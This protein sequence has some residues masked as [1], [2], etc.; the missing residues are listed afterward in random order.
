MGLRSLFSIIGKDFRIFFRSRIASFFVLVFPLII[1]LFA[2]FIFNSFA[3]S[4]VAIGSYSAGYTDLT[5]N[6]LA[7][8][9]ENN[10]EVERFGM[11][12]HCTDAVKSGRVHLCVIFPED[13][14]VA[15]NTE[16][17][18][19]YV[20]HSRINLAY[21]LINDMESQ[22][23]F[24][25]S[26]LGIHL[27]QDL[28]DVLDNVKESIPKRIDSIDSSKS[29]IED[30]SENI[31]SI[32]L[33][34]NLNGIIADL[35][36][37]KSSLNEEQGAIGDSIDDVILSI[38]SLEEINSQISD[39]LSEISEDNLEISD[40]LSRISSDLDKLLDSFDQASVLEAEK[41][42]SPIKTKIERVGED[43]N[44]RDYFFPTLF[45]LIALFGGILLSST[46]I[47]KER[48]TKAYFRNF[49]T[50]T[51][52]GT[53]ILG[54][55]LTCMI[56]LALQF[57][58]V[59]AGVHWVL[60]MPFLA[61]IGEIIL[62]LFL[63]LNVFIFIGMFLGY[64]FKSDETS[65]FASV[66]TASVLMFFSNTIFPVETISDS[67][68]V[69]ANFNPV[70][71]SQIALK[72]VMLFNLSYSSILNEIYIL[73]ALFGAFLLLTIIGRKISKRRL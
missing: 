10:Y 30:I 42:V 60:E 48:N 16:S 19:F 66:L 55:Y 5:E 43:S 21:I 17:I 50:P 53:F 59:F 3:L 8:F 11:P 54:S 34:S 13:L 56:L 26:E 57:A 67:F 68:K 47:L 38:E 33:Q 69:V 73:T 61:S 64:I 37:V 25:A 51:Y 70:V 44:N 40:S 18:L 15:G 52:D 27:A 35:N 36:N 41:I 65:A 32:T 58:I 46:F 14:S 63:S 62:I 29:D 31:D 23:S 20:D 39:D 7:G 12:E 71:V 9:E 1:V 28:I 6:I 22:I 2:G 24:E 49:M 72:K 45:T 4:G